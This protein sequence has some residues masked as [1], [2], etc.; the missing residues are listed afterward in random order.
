MWVVSVIKLANARLF[1]TSVTSERS[2]RACV[3]G[4]MVP[5]QFSELKYS[6]DTAVDSLFGT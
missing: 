2:P 3:C 6:I 4:R 5:F 1:N